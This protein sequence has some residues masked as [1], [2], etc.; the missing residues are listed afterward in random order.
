MTWLEANVVGDDLPGD[1][2]ASMLKQ[3]E[4]LGVPG[5]HNALC[6]MLVYPLRR[7]PIWLQAVLGTVLLCIG[8]AIWAGLGWSRLGEAGRAGPGQVGLGSAI[9]GKAMLGEFLSCCFFVENLTPA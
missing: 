1:R 7:L 9:P 8:A 5:A 3:G 4:A 6:G 2:L